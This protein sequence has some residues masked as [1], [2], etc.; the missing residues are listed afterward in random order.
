MRLSKQDRDLLIA[1]SIGDGHI[2]SYGQ[3]SINHCEKQEDYLRYKANLLK[4]ILYSDVRRSK[5]Y[6]KQCKKDIV[7]FHLSS[8]RV[9]FLKVLRKVLYPNNKKTI[10]RKLLNRVTEQGL[11]IWWMDDGNRNIQYRNGKIKYIM[12][13]LYTC[14]TKE[15]NRMILD[16]FKEKWD[17]NGYICKHGN[18]FIICFGSSEGK[19]LSNIIRPYIIDSMQ[20]KINPVENSGEI[21]KCKIFPV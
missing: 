16:W 9:K 11:A 14:V 2:N 7:Q 18:Q 4:K 15:L 3:L 1:M 21:S 5:I 17:L 13:R 19:K 12:Y 6:H 8:R 10:T 20:Y